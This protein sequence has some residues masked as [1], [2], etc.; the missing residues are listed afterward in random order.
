MKNY[1]NKIKKYYLEKATAYQKHRQ[2]IKLSLDNQLIA[3][4]EGRVLNVSIHLTSK[5]KNIF[6]INSLS[7]FKEYTKSIIIKLF[8]KDKGKPKEY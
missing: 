5:L 4:S 6:V 2:I 3:N 8:I 7:T 1:I